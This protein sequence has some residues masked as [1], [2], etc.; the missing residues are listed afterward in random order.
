MIVM[1]HRG[2]GFLFIIKEIYGN[3]HSKMILKDYLDVY[4]TVC[5]DGSTLNRSGSFVHILRMYS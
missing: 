4:P 5:W 3:R 2:C 1:A